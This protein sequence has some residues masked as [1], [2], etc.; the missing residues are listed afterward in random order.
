[1]ED[2]IDND[3]L[4]L[5]IQTLSGAVA[6]LGVSFETLA[7]ALQEAAVCSALSIGEAIT[8]LSKSLGLL[9]P[10]TSEETESPNQN[11]DLEIFEEKSKIEFDPCFRDRFWENESYEFMRG[12]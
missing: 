11:S 6:K 8:N 3:E 1:M 12:E 10:E 5:N 9:G 4:E 2:W 7:T